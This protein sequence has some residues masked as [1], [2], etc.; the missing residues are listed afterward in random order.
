[1]GSHLEEIRL[2]VFKFITLTTVKYLH[3]LPRIGQ[4]R[5]QKDVEASVDEVGHGI[6]YFFYVE[7]N[8]L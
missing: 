4:R 8:V 6:S 7:L 5:Q 2:V 3:R 1:M